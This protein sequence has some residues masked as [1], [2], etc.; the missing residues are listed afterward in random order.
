M[1][2]M[3]AFGLAVTQVPQ[4]SAKT[5]TMRFGQFAVHMRYDRFTG[6]WDCRLKGRRVGYHGGVV[7][8][9]FD[10]N[11]E[12]EQAEFRING[13]AVQTAAVY[14]DQ[15]DSL[16]LFSTIG[17][18]D[19]P[20]KSDVRLPPDLFSDASYIDIRPNPDKHFIGH[21]N[22]DGFGAAFTFMKEHGCKDMES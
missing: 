8:F 10:S 4:A 5:R 7:S 1:A 2:I 19:N 12:T 15:M 16:R 18:L 17:P 22:M 14:R 3:L 9:H 6:T 21:F 13:G 11:I 20:D